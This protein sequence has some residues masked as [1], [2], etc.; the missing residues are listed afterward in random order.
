M[1]RLRTSCSDNYNTPARVMD[2]LGQKKIIVTIT[3]AG[4][5]RRMQQTFNEIFRPR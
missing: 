3:S 1:I 4:E 5:Q 2:G